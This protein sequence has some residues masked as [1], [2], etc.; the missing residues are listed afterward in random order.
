MK[1]SNL[2][3]KCSSFYYENLQHLLDE[4]SPIN[5]CPTFS[6][7][8][9]A[10]SSKW[11]Y[12]HEDACDSLANIFVIHQNR[13]AGSYGNRLM[14]FP[15][16]LHTRFIHAHNRKFHVIRTR[17]NFQNIFHRRYKVGILVWRYLPVF[18]QVRLNFI[19]FKVL[20]TVIGETLGTI[21]NSTIFSANSRIVHRSRP[22][23]ASE[24]AMAKSLASNSPPN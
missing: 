7:F 15:D 21:F 2:I 11:F 3:R 24:Q 22:S 17:I 10:L 1:C 16:Q 4:M 12:L 18:A 8:Y 23:G 14:N 6:Y 19:F 13:M 9:L 20:H 5:P